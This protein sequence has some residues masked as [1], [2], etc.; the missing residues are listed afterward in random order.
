MNRFDCAL[1]SHRVVRRGAF[2]LAALVSTMLLPGKLVNAQCIDCSGYSVAVTPD[3]VSTASRLP[4]TVGY[5][6][7]FT[8]ENTGTSPD[9]YTITCGGSTNVTCTGTS[10]GSVPLNAGTVTTV[11]AYYNV[12]A[13]GIGT[14]SLTATSINAGNSFNSGSF[15]VPVVGSQGVA[16]TPDAE[17]GADRPDHTNGYSQAFTVQNTSPSSATFTITCGG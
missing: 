10:A 8:I 4:N 16:V 6:A 5:S 12:G 13:P 3:G 15:T 7:V 14:I 2:V 1:N 9:T 11:T 17:T